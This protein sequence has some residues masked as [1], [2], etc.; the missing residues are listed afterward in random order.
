[1]AQITVRETV[2]QELEGLAEELIPEVVNFIRFLKFRQEEERARQRFVI[3]IEKA[4]AV[5]RERGITDEDVQEEIRAARAG[6]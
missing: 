1:M 2:L 5:A 6:Q 3:A 4:R